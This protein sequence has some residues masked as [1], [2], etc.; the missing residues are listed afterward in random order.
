MKVDL[1]SST[2]QK[3]GTMELPA[4]LFEAPVN[5]G[6]MHQAM[7]MQRSNARSPIAHAKKR[8]EVAGSTRKVYGQKNTGRARRGPIRSPLMRG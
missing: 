2:G 8:S 6:L 7:V 4:E 5:R 3:A 1:Y